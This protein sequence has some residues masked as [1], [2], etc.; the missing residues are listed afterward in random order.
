MR[1]LFKIDCQLFMCIRKVSFLQPCSYQ[2]CVTIAFVYKQY[3]VRKKSSQCR[4]V[5][6]TKLILRTPLE[7]YVFAVTGYIEHRY[8]DSDYMNRFLKKCRLLTTDLEFLLIFITKICQ[9]LAT[10]TLSQ[11]VDWL[12]H[13]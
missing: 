5:L 2:F 9:S 6:S 12:G 11:L 10:Q 7:W 1:L 13:S 8:F 3:Y 4:C